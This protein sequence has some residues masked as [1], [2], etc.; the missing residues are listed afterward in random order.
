MTDLTRQPA[1][2]QLRALESREI[3]SRELLDLH[4]DRID[5]STLNAVITATTTRPGKPL[6]PPTSAEPAARPVGSSTAFRSLSRTAS[7]RQACARP[8][9]PRNWRTTFPTGTP[10]LSRGSATK[11]R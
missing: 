2:V 8:A 11:A 5:A 3:S 4:L 6:T 9:E 10:T 7:K 1:H